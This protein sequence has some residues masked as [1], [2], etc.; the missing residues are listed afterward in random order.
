MKIT[1]LKNL[2]GKGSFV[3][4][5]IHLRLRPIRLGIRPSC[6]TSCVFLKISRYPARYPNCGLKRFMDSSSHSC[7]GISAQKAT[8]F[9]WVIFRYS[10]IGK[11]CLHILSPGK[12]SQNDSSCLWGV[13]SWWSRNSLLVSQEEPFFGRWWN[14]WVLEILYPKFGQA[15]PTVGFGGSRSFFQ[16]GCVPYF[17]RMNWWLVLSMLLDSPCKSFVRDRVPGFVWS[18]CGNF[19]DH[20]HSVFQEHA[21]CEARGQDDSHLAFVDGS[22]MRPEDCGDSLLVRF[23]KSWWISEFTC[24]TPYLPNTSLELKHEQKSC[25]FSIGNLEMTNSGCVSTEEKRRMSW[26][27]SRDIPTF[28]PAWVATMHI[29]LAH[30]RL[31]TSWCSVSE[32]QWRNLWEMWMLLWEASLKAYFFT[33]RFILCDTI[34][35]TYILF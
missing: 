30:L 28:V 9:F 2:P 21:Q 29:V 12:F 35:I 20:F 25:V 31:S 4:R 16:N 13:G 10:K 23:L 24:L 11:F 5:R 27:R 7:Q 18:T 1:F 32:F 33:L 6:I 14:T 3:R 26:W 34:M 15:M 8:Y 19:F 22:I 17:D